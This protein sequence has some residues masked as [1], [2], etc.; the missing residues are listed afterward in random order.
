V[1]GSSYEPMHQ[2]SQPMDDPEAR[3]DTKTGTGTDAAASAATTAT[4]RENET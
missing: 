1:I 3:I 4:P 2:R